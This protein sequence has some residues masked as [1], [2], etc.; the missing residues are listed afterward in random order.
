MKIGSLVKGLIETAC[1][2]IAVAADVVVG[3]PL[4]IE[5]GKFLTEELLDKAKNDLN[6]TFE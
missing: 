1:L 3:I 5:K 6:E 2:P 4:K